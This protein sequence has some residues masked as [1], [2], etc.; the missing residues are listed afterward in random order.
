MTNILFVC[1]RNR[2]RSPTAE[3][4]FAERPGIETASSGT[5]P[6]ADEP[7]TADSIAWADVVFVMEQTHRRKLTAQFG[8]ALNGKRIVC[9]D[10]P[11]KYA[12]MDPDLVRLL[13]AKVSRHLR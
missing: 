8:K 7:V 11:D 12:F 9:L 2:R 3:K 6:D 4:I 1:S 10:I 13:T 5:S